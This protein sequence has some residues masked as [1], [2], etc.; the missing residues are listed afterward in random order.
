M[1]EISFQ[2]F[3]MV[4]PIGDELKNVEFPMAS[5]KDALT[6]I[7]SGHPIG[8]GRMLELSNNKD[9]SGLGYNSQDLKKP[10]MIVEKG[11]VLPL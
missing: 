5:F 1:K 9:R 7:R 6:I 3:E 4:G 11:Q 2:S 10:M 8:W